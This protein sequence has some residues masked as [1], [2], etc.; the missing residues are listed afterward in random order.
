MDRSRQAL[1]SV[2]AALLLGAMPPAASAQYKEARTN[3]DGYATLFAR[4]LEAARRTPPAPGPATTSTWM[5]DLMSDRRA[6]SVN[7]LVTVHVIESIEAIG[8]ADS[9]LDKTGS[10]KVAVTNLVGLEDEYDDW[11]DP[12]SVVGLDHNTKFKGGGTTTRSGSLTAM[13]TAR[14]VEVLPS[15]DLVLE[16]VREVDI[17]GDRQIVVLSG[18]ARQAD[19]NRNNVVPSTRIGQLQIRYFGQG[20]IKDNLK[21]GWLIRLLNKV[22]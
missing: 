22:F 4:Y 18:V 6:H 11:F 2:A 14:V 1:V 13:M 17:N 16:G 8:Q 5:T 19:I 15:G 20:L 21:P 9:Q 3:P 12:T 7:D 10:A